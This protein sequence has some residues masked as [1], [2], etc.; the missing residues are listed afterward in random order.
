MGT[1]QVVAENLAVLEALASMPPG[2]GDAA[3]RARLKHA[4]L[5][6]ASSAPTDYAREKIARAHEL[7]EIWLSPK[8]WRK[9]GL[10]GENLHVLILQEL[11]K[12]RTALARREGCA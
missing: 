9:W 4:A 10:D 2:V 7:L 6:L 11:S 8:R 5:T 3:A 1:D 12:T